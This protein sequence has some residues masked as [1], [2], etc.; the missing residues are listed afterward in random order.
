MDRIGHNIFFIHEHRFITR[1]SKPLVEFIFTSEIHVKSDSYSTVN[2]NSRI[3]KSGD[4]CNNFWK[5]SVWK[6]MFKILERFGKI[7]LEFISRR[8]FLLTI[9]KS[10]F[11]VPVINKLFYSEGVRRIFDAAII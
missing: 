5:F 10:L 4:H 8:K 11:H 6:V 2:S 7:V 3:I 1:K 9:I